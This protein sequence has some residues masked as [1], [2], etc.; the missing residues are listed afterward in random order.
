[1]ILENRLRLPPDFSSTD[2]ILVFPE[3]KRTRKHIREEI[4]ALYDAYENPTELVA[5]LGG[6][7][8]KI[9]GTHFGAE[10]LRE[11]GAKYENSYGMAARL[12]LPA[13]FMRAGVAGEF[14]LQYEDYLISKMLKLLG[15]EPHSTLTTSDGHTIEIGSI[16][17]EYIQ[18]SKLARIETEFSA[19]VYGEP[20]AVETAQFVLQESAKAGVSVP[21][22]LQA[23]I[24]SN[25]LYASGLY[26]AVH[27]IIAVQNS[28]PVRTLGAFIHETQH[29]NQGE[30]LSLVSELDAHNA[31]HTLLQKIEAQK[32]QDPLAALY[33][34]MR[35]DYGTAVDLI[36]GSLKK[37]PGQAIMSD[38]NIESYASR[39]DVLA[40]EYAVMK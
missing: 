19:P 26:S 29:A 33:A 9:D 25:T 17:K 27:R 31:T 14:M 10:F 30:L 39:V 2:P 24:F 5:A 32:A 15:K 21:S 18:G 38:H 11:I 28:L 40:L 20:E 22:D 6:Y 13:Q 8:Q 1:M 34:A 3:I 16:E 35:V 23:V 7:F 4:N 37:D 12:V 36:L